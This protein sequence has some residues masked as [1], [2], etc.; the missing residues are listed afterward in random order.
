M[1]RLYEPLSTSYGRQIRHNRY[2]SP[3]LPSLRRSAKF[4]ILS[5]GPCS[6]FGLGINE[7]HDEAT[8]IQVS[9]LTK[10]YN[11]YPAIQDVSFEVPRGQIVGLLGPNGAGKS[12]TMRI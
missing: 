5:T 8:V 7:H 11:D 6:R 12:T 10:Y 9:N 4:S 3:L 1:R 2:D